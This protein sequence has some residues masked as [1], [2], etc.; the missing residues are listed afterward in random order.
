[1]KQYSEKW[2]SKD[3]ARLGL[4][5]TSVEEH[6]FFQHIDFLISRLVPD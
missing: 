4:M 1:M 3:Y 6:K 5:L 2:S